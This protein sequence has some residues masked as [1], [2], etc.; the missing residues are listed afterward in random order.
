MS[1]EFLVTWMM[2]FL[3]TTGVILQ[4]PAVAGR[5]IPMLARGGICI[6]IASL[7]VGVVPRADIPLTLGALALAAGGELL[8]GL[9]L[10]FVGRMAFAAVE[11]AGRL[12]STEIG[13]S[14]SPGMGV[15]E[16]S[17]E[18]LA[19][20]LSTF[21]IVM[22]FLFGGHLMMLSALARSFSLILTG[23]P[24]LGPA[25]GDSMIRAT[26]HMIE[27][28][29][30]MAAPFIAM[31]FLVTMSFSALGRVVPKMNPFIIS[32]SVKLMAGFTLL[33]SAGALMARYLYEEF[34]E[35]PLR[36]LQVITGN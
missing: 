28:G 29:V 9:A 27:L 19:A 34:S 4:L 14:A 21:A 20:L 1:L 30:R 18:P 26:S 7:L 13:L 31:N 23:N 5:P 33:A 16:P 15:P 35:T 36:M 32:F 24:V 3:R 12:I 8:L 10:G 11:M 6:C 17:T 22:F 2:V 25:A